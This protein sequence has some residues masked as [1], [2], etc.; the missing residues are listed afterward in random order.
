MGQFVIQEHYARSHHFDFRLEKDGVF[1]SWAVPK[2]V[3]LTE[4]TRRLA[5]QVDDHALDFGDFE[6]I[7]P[8]G[9]YGAC[10]ISIWDKGIYE[11]IEWLT[12]GITFKLQG[13]RINGLFRLTRFTDTENHKWLLKKISPDEIS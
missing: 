12:N 7:I 8:E 3:P 4:G 1:K 6:G 2:G 9:Q 11:P 5:I 10:K 13:S